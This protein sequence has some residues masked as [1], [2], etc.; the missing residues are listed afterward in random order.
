MAA[1]ESFT[2]ADNQPPK[3]AHLMRADAVVDGEVEFTTILW[4]ECFDCIKN[5]MGEDYQRAHV[6]ES[7]QALLKRF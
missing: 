5:F 6:P 7:V 4:F 1:S 3:T 2:S